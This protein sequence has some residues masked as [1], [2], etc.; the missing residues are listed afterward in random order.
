MDYLKPEKKAIGF[1]LLT[2]LPLALIAE[3]GL[4]VAIYFSG[5]LQ[6]VAPFLYTVIAIAMTVIAYVGIVRPI[7]L[8]NTY[9]IRVEKSYVEICYRAIGEHCSIT[10]LHGKTEYEIKKYPLF[11]TM[12]RVI[13]KNGGHKFVVRYLSQKDTETLKETI[14][15]RD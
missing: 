2:H 13:L 6:G 1:A 10:P 11:K 7:L 4:G 3:G 14:D 12:Y 15:D 8:C 9:R 5:V